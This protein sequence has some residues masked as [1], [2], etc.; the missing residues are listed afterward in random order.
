[1]PAL[2][3][4]R[5]TRR[6]PPQVGQSRDRRAHNIRGAFAME[7]RRDVAGKRLVLVD[8]VRTTGSTLAECARVLREAGAAEV[9]AL[10]VTFEP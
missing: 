5:R 2:P 4:L 9:F 3:A 7:P 8:D 6:T 10:T 1:V